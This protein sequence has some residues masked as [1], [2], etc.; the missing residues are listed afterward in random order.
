MRGTTPV[1][2]NPTEVNQ[3]VSVLLVGNLEV[4][5]YSL[6]PIAGHGTLELH[7]TQNNSINIMVERS[8]SRTFPVSGVLRV[9]TVVQFVDAEFPNGRHEE[10]NVNI[11]RIIKGETKD[12]EI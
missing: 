7:P 4:A 5:R 9:S 10:F 3:I 11:G 1:V 6:N 8:Q 12:I 2:L